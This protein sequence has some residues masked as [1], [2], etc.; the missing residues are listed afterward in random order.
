[1]L[2]GSKLLTETPLILTRKGPGKQVLLLGGNSRAIFSRFLVYDKKSVV[3]LVD[4]SQAQRPLSASCPLT[5]SQKFREGRTD[6]LESFL[7]PGIWLARGSTRL[8][9]AP[10]RLI[11]EEHEKGLT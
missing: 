3:F 5:M 9:R 7:F 2:V 10:G 11:E 4:P 1:M 6:Y 8:G